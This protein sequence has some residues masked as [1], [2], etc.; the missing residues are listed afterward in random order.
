M[1]ANTSFPFFLPAL[2]SFSGAL[3]SDA[4]LLCN[5]GA[6]GPPGGGGDRGTCQL[7]T[8]GQGPG[9]RGLGQGAGTGVAC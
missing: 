8:K 7:M 3:S 5:L 1:G 4:M 6:E 2:L 9:G